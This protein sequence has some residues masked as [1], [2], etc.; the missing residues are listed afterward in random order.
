MPADNKARGY[1][2]GTPDGV[3]Y[4][5]YAEAPFAKRGGSEPIGGIAR[6]EQTRS[7]IKL[8]PDATL[9]FTLTGALISASD[10]SSRGG[11]DDLISGELFLEVHA[12]T[13]S[14]SFFHTAGGATVTGSSA[15]WV[16]RSGTTDS[17]GRRCG[18]K[19]TSSS[20]PSTSSIPASRPAEAREPISILKRSRTYTVDLSSIAVGEEF[21]LKTFAFAKALNRRGGGAAGDCE[22][23]AALAYLRDP[24]E[25]GGTTVRLH[26][27]CS[28]PTTRCCSRRSRR[29]SCPQPAFP[30]LA[31][32]PRR[33]PCSSAPP[34]TPSASSRAP[35]RRCGSRAAAAA[36]AP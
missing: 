23:S 30:G 36:A 1:I 33:A 22:A 11:V 17:R 18:A 8:S 34:A 29:R 35:R 20:T 10:A 5:V 13:S 3:T 28:R 2:F 12:Y 21:T 14:R 6:L 31:P 4:G 7:F 16:P 15:Q 9:T 32:T 26:R 19:A 25:I 24:L 27:A